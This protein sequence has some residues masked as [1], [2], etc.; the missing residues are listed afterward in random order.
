MDGPNKNEIAATL[1]DEA[2]VAEVI[3]SLF[4]AIRPGRRLRSSENGDP[5]LVK[6]AFVF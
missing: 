4:E 1:D 6:R 5:R 3:R 2:D